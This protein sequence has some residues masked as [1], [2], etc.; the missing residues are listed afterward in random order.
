MDALMGLLDAD[1]SGAVDYEELSHVGEITAGLQKLEAAL[2]ADI[3]GQV[4]AVQPFP[5]W[6]LV[7]IIFYWKQSGLHEKENNCTAR[8]APGG[9]VAAPRRADGRAARAGPAAGWN[10]STRLTCERPFGDAGR[11]QSDKTPTSARERA[12]PAPAPQVTSDMEAEVGRLLVQQTA[13]TG[14]KLRAE[15]GAISVELGTIA[16]ELDAAREKEAQMNAFAADTARLAVGRDA[17]SLQ[18]ALSSMDMGTLMVLNGGNSASN[19][20][21]I[22][23]APSP[24]FRFARRLY[25]TRLLLFGRVLW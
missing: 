17:I 9:G 1:G 4:Q 12:G 8:V 18:A 20:L 24:R 21:E 2:A 16:E 6:S 10:R 19:I 25:T 14:E 23:Y 15:V 11:S 7:F 3:A 22:Y 5:H 13:R